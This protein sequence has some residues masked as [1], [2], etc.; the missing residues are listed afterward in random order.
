[1]KHQ[2]IA[3]LVEIIE[4]MEEEKLYLSIFFDKL[5]LEYCEKGEIANWSSKS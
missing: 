4:D 1:V 5:V 2:Y 3:G